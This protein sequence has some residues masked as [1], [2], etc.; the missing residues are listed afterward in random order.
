MAA[1][2]LE[3]QKPEIIEKEGPAEIRLEDGEVSASQLIIP[4]SFTV[5]QQIDIWICDTG[6]SRGPE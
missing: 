3:D 6:A 5:L 2:S 1:E 4:T